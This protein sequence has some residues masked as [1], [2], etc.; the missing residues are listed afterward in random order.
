M[1]SIKKSFSFQVADKSLLS[2]IVYPKY[3]YNN[4]SIKNII[5]TMYRMISTT[6]IHPSIPAHSPYHVDKYRI[7]P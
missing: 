5:V 1:V 3:K 6:C 2:C 7:S 4:K